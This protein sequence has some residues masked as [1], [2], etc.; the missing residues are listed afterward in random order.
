M[1]ARETDL[2]MGTEPEGFRSTKAEWGG[3][4]ATFERASAGFDTS[5]YFADQPDGS[6]PVEHWGYLIKGRMLVRYGDHEE[7][8]SEGEAYHLAPGHNVI[9]LDDI[10]MVEFTPR[11]KFGG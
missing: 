11:Q 9:A 5:P 4:R 7:T 1:H 6:C 2:P 8:V 3:C 10:Q